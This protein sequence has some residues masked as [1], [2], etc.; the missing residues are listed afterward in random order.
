MSKEHYSVNP[1]SSFLTKHCRSQE[2][3][4]YPQTGEVCLSIELQCNWISK[5]NYVLR[6]RVIKENI[7]RFVRPIWAWISVFHLLDW[8]IICFIRRESE[9]MYYMTILLWVSHHN[10]AH[11]ECMMNR[12]IAK[13]LI[14]EITWCFQ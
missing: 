1:L 10:C 8:N 14:F 9:C 6:R 2:S 5:S 3:I 4:N 12:T 7:V 11:A 13:R